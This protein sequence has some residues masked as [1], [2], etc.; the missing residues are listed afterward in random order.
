MQT[1][2]ATTHELLSVG[3]LLVPLELRIMD[4][5]DYSFYDLSTS[6]FNDLHRQ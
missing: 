3:T 6:T 4:E 5:V 1:T 2:T